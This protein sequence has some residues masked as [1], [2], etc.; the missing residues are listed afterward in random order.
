[1]IFNNSNVK[2][3]KIDKRFPHI[4]VPEN[5]INMFLDWWNTDIRY[6]H[7]IP[8]SFEEGYM[9]IKNNKINNRYYR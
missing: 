8:H 9:T 5:K 1:M 6:E 4:I 2:M 3:L 7:T